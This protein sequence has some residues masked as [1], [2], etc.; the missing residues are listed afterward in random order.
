MC[1]GSSARNAAYYANLRD[2]A[3]LHIDLTTAEVRGL[4]VSPTL[5]TR[6]DRDRPLY[7]F[8]FDG[9]DKIRCEKVYECSEL[10]SEMTV[11]RPQHAKRSGAIG[12]VIEHGDEQAFAKLPANREVRQVG[13]A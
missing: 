13:Y 7:C 5:R 6:A 8:A 1:I 9:R 4:E 11:R 3:E 12:V 10:W 2:C